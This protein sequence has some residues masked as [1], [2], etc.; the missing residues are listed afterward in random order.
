MNRWS[1]LQN[2]WIL[3][4]PSMH[5]APPVHKLA[6]NWNSASPS[7]SESSNPGHNISCL[8]VVWSCDVQKNGCS[9]CN[10]QL[11]GQ[12]ISQ[13][14][15]PPCKTHQDQL[16]GF[17]TSRACS[18][19]NKYVITRNKGPK[20]CFFH[21]QYP[22]STYAFS[23]NHILHATTCTYND[24]LLCLW[25]FLMDFYTLCYNEADNNQIF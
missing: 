7:T 14:I 9:C 3:G 24:L 10:N 6:Y 19:I 13:L 5:K 16:V 17:D 12:S 1:I 18:K 22:P 21:E 8:S 20:E 15:L 11:L 2:L 25:L 4:F 23:L